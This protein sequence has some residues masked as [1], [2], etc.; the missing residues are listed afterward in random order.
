MFDVHPP[1]SSIHSW[2]DIA[3]QLFVVTLGLLIALALEGCVEWLHHRHVMHQAESSLSV[4]IKANA[5]KIQSAIDALHQQQTA[6]KKDVAILKAMGAHQESVEHATLD[7]GFSVKTFDDVSW[8]TAQITGAVAYMPYKR[9]QAYSQ[10]YSQQSELVALEQQAAR[11]TTLAIAPLIN[12]DDG[13][14]PT[15]EEA[16]LIRRKIEVLQGQLLIV[17]KYLQSMD[18][19]YRTF[20]LTSDSR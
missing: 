7:I 13:T 18:E 10:M 5:A 14:K 16:V 11:D 6:L 15:Q 20:L 9:A 3:L 4:E 1:H 8:K 17:E 19:L 12:L 2:R